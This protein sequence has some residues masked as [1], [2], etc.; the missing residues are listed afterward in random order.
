MASPPTLSRDGQLTPNA[1]VLNLME[2]GR[3]L[4]A[5]VRSLKDAEID[6]VTKRHTADIEESKAYVGAEGPVETRKHLARIAADHFES[7]ALVAE[8][9]VR[10]LRQRVN[11]I[12]TR[13]D[14]GRSLGAALRAELSNL[15]G[16]DG[17]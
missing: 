8:S 14:I 15:G 1:V 6:A 10:Y 3:E 16:A 7:E 13:I 2:L 17:P 5:V 12:S 4:D 11:A 9:V